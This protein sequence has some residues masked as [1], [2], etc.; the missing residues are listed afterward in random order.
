MMHEPTPYTYDRL[1]AS[2][3][4]ALVAFG[5]ALLSVAC[6]AEGAPPD[7]DPMCTGAKCD[8]PDDPAAL[9][10]ERGRGDAFNPNKLAFTTN[11]L[12][13]SCAD[14]PGVTA[15]DR[16]QEYCE[17]FAIVEVPPTSE[18]DDWFET[19]V[20][21]RNLGADSS[22]GTTPLSVELNDYQIEWLEYDESEV[23]GQC[24][25]TSWNS[26]FEA[27]APACTAAS[28]PEVFGVRATADVF[29]MGFEVNSTD[30]A[31]LLVADCA[32]DT[33]GGDDD[34]Y[35]RGCMLNDELNGTAFRKSDSVACA[36]SMRLAEC[37][38]QTTT[39]V[40]LDVALAPWERRGFPLGTWSGA[41]QLPASC[42]YLDLG[43]GSQT[44]VTC[45][46]T[47]ADILGSASDPK[48]RCRDKYAD[49]VVVHVPVPAQ[50]ITCSGGDSPYTSTCSAT[51]WVVEP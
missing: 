14:V 41:S 33:A 50:A 34:D 26:D 28:C 11:A 42:R 1:R 12:R 9:S 23:V 39:G 47:A 2:V 15:E 17:Y 48:G 27:P 51:P 40:A 38:C 43:D 22:Y 6:G 29:R 18:A 35:L 10:C 8:V 7:D 45:D 31:Q 16:G 49:N 25:F 37:G 19:A 36:A 21:G 32:V 5:L 46:L 20:L 30:A 24:V 44:V 13:W 4:W 3:C